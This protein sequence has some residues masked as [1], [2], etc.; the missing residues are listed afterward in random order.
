MLSLK[1][2]WNLGRAPLRTP[3]FTEYVQATPSTYTFKIPLYKIIS[4]TTP[5]VSP[6]NQTHYIYI[7]FRIRRCQIKN[8]TSVKPL[9]RN[10]FSDIW[11]CYERLTWKLLQQND[12]LI[13]SYK[14]KKYRQQQSLLI[15]K[16]YTK[17]PVLLNNPEEKI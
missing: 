16:M 15:N 1:I 17:F 4:M 8:E 7:C 10:H 9:W 14:S 3:F 11:F 12:K 6:F 2:N 5:A 13:A